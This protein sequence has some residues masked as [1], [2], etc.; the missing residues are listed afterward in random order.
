MK[1]FRVNQHNELE[2][3]NG[4]LRAIKEFRE[5]LLR[6]RRM[7]GDHEGRK[8]LYA[9]HEFMYIYFY[10]DWKSPYAGLPDDERHEAALGETDLIE[11]WDE[12]KP[13]ALVKAA[14]EKYIELKHTP[15]VKLIINLQAG[16]VN[17]NKIV[18]FCNTRINQIMEET[19]DEADIDKVQDNAKLV[20]TQLNQIFDISNKI[21]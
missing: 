2:I 1:L 13:D 10:C 7:K 19:K 18:E 20:Q 8:K 12:W 5:L 6:S 11:F 3:E 15:L 9:T 16:L 21:K 4:E 17:A 14:I